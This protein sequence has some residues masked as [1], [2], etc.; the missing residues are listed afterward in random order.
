MD[1]L[2]TPH[3][4]IPDCDCHNCALCERDNLRRALAGI[5]EEMGLPPTIGPAKGDLKRLLDSGTVAIDALRAAPMAVSAEADFDVLTWTF[6]IAP[7]CRVGAGIY[8]LV[9]LGP[10]AKLTGRGE[11]D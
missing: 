2:I 1:E 7:D 6:K 3:D 5:S 8:A 10:N 11:T 4:P 9:C